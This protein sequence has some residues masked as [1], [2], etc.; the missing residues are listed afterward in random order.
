[1]RRCDVTEMS[2]FGAALA[3]LALLVVVGAFGLVFFSPRWTDIALPKPVPTVV[4]VDAERAYDI[5]GKLCNAINDGDQAEADR[6]ARWLDD[7]RA[8]V[9]VRDLTEA[10]SQLIC[11]WCGQT[12]E[13][14][15]PTPEDS[16]GIC[17]SCME[18]WLA[19][20]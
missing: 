11:A 17:D 1:M 4:P 8:G 16:H 20:E 5:Y 13:E 14:D 10:H 9:S 7:Y 2:S 6:L 15:Y 18:K 3:G 12:I 19:G